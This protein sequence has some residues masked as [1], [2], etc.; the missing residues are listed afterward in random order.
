MAEAA[1][2]EG[3]GLMTD[4][5]RRIGFGLLLGMLVVM[6]CWSYPTYAARYCF[7][8]ATRGVHSEAEYERSLARSVALDPSYGHARLLHAR[9][10]MK[11]GA[12]GAAYD[13]QVAG[14]SSFQ[15]VRAYAQMGSI[16]EKIGR[17]AEA[18]E[19]FTR[20]LRMYPLAVDVMESLAVLALRAGDS[21]ELNRVLRDLQE[22]D[23][24]NPNAYYL[25]ARDAERTGQTAAALL[26][27][28]R[29][30]TILA[31]GAQDRT[32]L[33]FDPKEVAAR[34]GELQ[35]EVSKP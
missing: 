9:L 10:M 5:Y 35:T 32:R 20:A 16:C 33:L 22:L 28:Q 12:Y 26:N 29:L 15:P 7:V 24:A 17:P 30:S 3:V 1:R 31:R 27:Y 6:A 11:R 13:D 23:V 34:I 19:W 14:M 8:E 21:T 2:Q 25:L 4:T 18:A